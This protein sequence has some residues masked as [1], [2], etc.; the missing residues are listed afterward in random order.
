VGGL[1]GAIRFDPG[2]FSNIRQQQ[3]MKELYVLLMGQITL[4]ENVEKY[5]VTHTFT[6]AADTEESVDISDLGI[7]WTPT[8]A[9]VIE[10]DDGAV[11][12]PSDKA[13]WTS[14]TI[15][16]KSTKAGTVVILGVL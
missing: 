16:L 12:Y 4:R 1:M 15:K 13:S 3:L 5:L 6:V 9:W 10:V 8:Y 2:A 7:E 14:S 11:V